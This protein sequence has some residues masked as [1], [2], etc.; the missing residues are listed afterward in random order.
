MTESP[1]NA[2]NGGGERARLLKARSDR[3]KALMPKRPMIHVE[4]TKDDYR[5]YLKHPNGTAFPHGGGGIDWPNDR[6]TQRRIADG[7]V[8]AIERSEEK[9][10]PQ[11]PRQRGATG[12]TEPTA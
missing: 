10:T 9:R 12:T 8:K 7:S 6:F 1:K 4:P 3:V 2:P 5:K 11:P